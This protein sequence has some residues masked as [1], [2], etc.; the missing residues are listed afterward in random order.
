MYQAS[1]SSSRSQRFFRYH[2][3]ALLYAS[4]IIILSSIQD[5]RPPDIDIPSLD[6]LIHLAEY[7]IFAL[8]TFRS[9]YHLGKEPNLRRSLSLSALFV[10]FFAL[11]DEL[12]QRF[13]PGR[14]SDWRDFLVDI[15]GA[16]IVLIVLGLFRRA[17]RRSSY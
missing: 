9:V 7:A 2:F 3:P 13:V 4:G 6:K 10:S 1:P 5:L 17:R 14:H 15:L 16:C 11:L 12:Y 8:L